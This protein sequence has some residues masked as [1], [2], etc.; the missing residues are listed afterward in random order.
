[1]L[2]TLDASITFPFSVKIGF[3][4][5]LEQYDALSNSENEIIAKKAKAILK[6]AEDNPVLREGFTDYEELF[7]YKD[8]INIV[9]QDVFSEVLTLNEIKFATIP[10]QNT[11]LSSTQRFKNIIND[12]GEEFSLAIKNMPDD[13]L[14]I[15]GCTIIISM[16]YGYSLNFKRP[17]YY[18]IP[19]CNGILRTYKVLYNADFIEI[20]PTENAPKFT[21]A[22]YEELLDNFDDIDL[23]KQKFPPNSYQFN[24]FVISSMFDVTDDQSISNIKSTLIQINNREKQSFIENFENVFQRLFNT[25]D[26]KVGFSVFTQEENAL[27]QAYQ[28]NIK[29]YLLNHQE[30]I[31]CKEALCIFSYDRLIKDKNYYS[32]SDVEK[33]YQLSQ[34]K[35]PQLKALKDQGIKSA[36]FAPI[37]EDGELLAI[38]ELVSSKKG[39]LNSIN[40]NKLID[41]MP[42]ILTAVKR[43]KEEEENQIEAIIQR[44]CTSI[45][46]SVRWKF[47]E[48]ARLF[49]K[50]QQEGKPNPNFKRISFKKV[51]PLFGQIDVKGSS[52]ERNDATLKDLQLQLKLVKNII[53]KASKLED[54]PIY[55]QLK[56]QINQFNDALNEQFKVDTEQKLTQFFNREIEPVLKFQLNKYEELEEDIK[57]YFSKIDDNLNVI[58]FY[59]KNF[60]DT[61]SLINKNM[62]T[63]IDRKQ[64]EAQKMYPHFFERY[65]TDGVEH[66]MYIGEAIT[67]EDSFNEIYLYNLR[68]WQMQVMCEMENSYYNYQHEYPKA[69]DVASMILVFNQPLSIRFRTDEK[70]FDVDG[71][72]NARY[73]VVKK[74]V[75]KANI[76]GTDERATQKGKLTIVYS[77]QEDE[78]EYLQYVKFLQ[79]KKRLANN[80]EILELEDLQGVTGLKAIRVDILYND[81]S[82][83]VYYT[84]DDLVKDNK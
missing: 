32:I 24:G 76:K 15:F 53:D 79:A 67:K 43:A 62:A 73:E 83:G 64:V 34:G 17:I 44:E 13:D 60:D 25:K 4:K 2:K 6:V 38:L 59:R 3:N 48:A 58:Y 80:L 7:E 21:K 18:D 37:A 49:R 47:E 26:I 20:L 70:H 54:L 84:Y 19:D 23:W 63:I 22:D 27:T 74:R 50:E 81:K 71:T 41:V 61:I 39:E 72:Y 40:A 75:D 9:L 31:N 52:K 57:D 14:Y 36:I 77:Q 65:K 16:Y 42:F 1:M 35:E 68:L 12:A 29:S 55:K 66:N 28:N 10:L 5:L 45:H 82:E 33:L 78:D 56:F 11:V 69:L 51:Y 30:T 46:P 8:E